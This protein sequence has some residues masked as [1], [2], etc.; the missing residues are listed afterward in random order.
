LIATVP[1]PIDSSLG[2]LFD[3]YLVSIQ[4]AMEAADYVLDRFELPWLE[5]E[6]GEAVRAA[7][8][9]LERL[10]VAAPKRVPEPYLQ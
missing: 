8:R 2:Y 1:D 6:Q 3:R 7:D 10:G 4:R 5:K 9:V